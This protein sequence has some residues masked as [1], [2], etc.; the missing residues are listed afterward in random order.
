[1]SNDDV[2]DMS[3]PT[4]L[5]KITPET[6]IKHHD[7]NRLIDFSTIGNN[8]WNNPDRSVGVV[9][10]SGGEGSRLGYDMPKGTI[11]LHNNI[12]LF[13]V[14]LN[15]LKNIK[16]LSVMKIFLFIMVSLTTKDSVEKW[17]KEFF[18]T[19]N[20]NDY[21]HGFEIFTQNSLPILTLSDKK[22]IPGFTSPNGNGGMYEVLKTCNNYSKTEIFNV[23]S[24]DN[25]AAQVLDPLFLGCLYANQYDV[26]NKSIKPNSG[27]KVGGFTFYN[28]GDVKIEEYTDN[29]FDTNQSSLVRGN[30]CNH[31]LTKSFIDKI[32]LT[33]LERHHAIKDA[34]K[35][36]NTTDKIIKQE[37]FIF[38]TFSQSSKVGVL[39]VERSTEFIPLKDKND[40]EKVNA[41]IKNIYKSQMM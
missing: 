12:T 9:I 20:Q 13:D 30:I 21:C 5:T 31:L 39:T 34:K 28:N 7:S 24:V 14:H 32:D 37:L 10:L 17:F 22:E 8:I 1:M 19:H 25:V 38:D 2:M 36:M 35:G 11:P 40:I 26:L 27:E 16:K 4:L 23:I 15:K 33:Q 3:N 18:E 29:G 6:S 41:Y